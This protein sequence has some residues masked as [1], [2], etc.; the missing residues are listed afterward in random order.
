L[1]AGIPINVLAGDPFALHAHSVE[2]LHHRLCLR[3]DGVG[4]MCRASED[5]EKTEDAKGR[6]DAQRHGQT[7]C[8]DR[9]PHVLKMSAI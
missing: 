6:G 4:R 8:F 1:Q 5:H 2:R 3:R 9:R 7:P